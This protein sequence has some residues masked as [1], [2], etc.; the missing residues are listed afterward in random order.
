MAE[1]NESENIIDKE[2]N[3]FNKF[4]GSFK[5]LSYEFLYLVLKDDDISPFLS[6]FFR[7]VHYF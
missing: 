4:A 1:D 6:C 7:L 5:G 2:I 3:S